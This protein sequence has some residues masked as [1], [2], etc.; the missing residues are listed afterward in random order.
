MAI[1]KV[2]QNSKTKQTYSLSGDGDWFHEWQK[3]N[4]NTWNKIQAIQRVL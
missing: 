1:E 4:T 2:V 3:E